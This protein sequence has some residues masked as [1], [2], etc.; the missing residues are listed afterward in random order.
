MI[1]TN[2][3]ISGN[4]QSM[5]I[6]ER[7]TQ[8]L[9]CAIGKIDSRF[10]SKFLITIQNNIGFRKKYLEYLVRL[11]DLSTPVLYETDQRPRIEIF[12]SETDSE[13]PGYSKIFLRD[14]AAKKWSE[15]INNSGYL[16]R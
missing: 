12:E 4:D 2:Q 15:F 9:L 3:I 16:R 11:D 7:L 13:T 6:A 5:I 1:K 14:T 10:S 8:R